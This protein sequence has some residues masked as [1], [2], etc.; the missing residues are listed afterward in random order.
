MVPKVYLTRPI[1]VTAVQWTKE[2]T[3]QVIDWILSVG[4]QPARWHDA[5][6]GVDTG[7]G[8]MWNAMPEQIHI[9]RIDRKDY[10]VAVLGD[11][12]ILGRG[13]EFF[14]CSESAFPLVYDELP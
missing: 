6:P 4:E 9:R 8:H 12:I 5:N 1:A 14:V 11:W 10:Y 13:N 7:S 2:N 3:S